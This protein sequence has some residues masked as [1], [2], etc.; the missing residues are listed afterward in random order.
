MVEIE[1]RDIGGPGLK[2]QHMAITAK[3]G[4]EGPIIG[5]CS[6]GPIAGQERSRIKSSVVEKQIGHS[7]TIRHRYEVS[8]NTAVDNET[9]IGTQI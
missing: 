9:S 3:G 2:R 6:T 1:R 5:W 8:G 4:D 7:G